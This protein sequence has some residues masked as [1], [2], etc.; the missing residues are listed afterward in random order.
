MFRSK[1]LKELSDFLSRPESDDFDFGVGKDPR[2]TAAD[3]FGGLRGRQGALERVWCDDDLHGAEASRE[4][5]PIPS[6]G[7]PPQA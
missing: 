2:D 4:P 1:R 5:P 6:F 3:G 7:F